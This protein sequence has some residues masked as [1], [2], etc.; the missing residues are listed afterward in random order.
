MSRLFTLILTFCVPMGMMAHDAK[1]DGEPSVGA[2]GMPGAM[3][4]IEFKPSDW[5]DENTWWKDTDGIAPG[6]A[7]CHIGTDS[8]GA[9]NSRT[10]GEAC[11]ENGLLVET[12]PGAYA[13]HKRDTGHPPDTF[14]CNEWCRL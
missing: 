7:G 2:Q 6:M 12:N 5:I 1:A 11:L 9:P 4:T 8:K 3:G 10:F 14:D 13:V